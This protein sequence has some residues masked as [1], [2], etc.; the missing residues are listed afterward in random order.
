MKMKQEENIVFAEDEKNTA[1]KKRYVKPEL[2]A[3][4]LFADEVLSLC[5]T[6]LDG[7]GQP[8]DS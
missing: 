2:K 7:C 6:I 5:R 4:M 1:Q 3:V 8:I